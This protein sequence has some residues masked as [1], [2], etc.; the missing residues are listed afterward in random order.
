VEV[1]GV[2]LLSRLFDI[3]QPDSP[4]YL[5]CSDV[6]ETFPELYVEKPHLKKQHITPRFVGNA[7]E[8]RV[9]RRAQERRGIRA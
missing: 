8:R 1:V 5:T 6:P 2:W 3:N 7:H 9:Q 4:E